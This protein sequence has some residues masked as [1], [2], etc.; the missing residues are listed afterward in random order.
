MIVIIDHGDNYIR[1]LF[2]Q[3]LFFFEIL[4]FLG[5]IFLLELIQRKIFRVHLESLCYLDDLKEL[6]DSSIIRTRGTLDFFA[7]PIYLEMVVGG[8]GFQVLD[9]V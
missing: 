5:Q 2:K 3:G 7:S 6:H 8:F 1:Q 9:V 4:L